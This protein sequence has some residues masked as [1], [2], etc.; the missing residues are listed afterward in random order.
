MIRRLTIGALIAY[1]AVIAAFA[2]AYCTAW[3][4]DFDRN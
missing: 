4:T 1:L 3:L 2:I